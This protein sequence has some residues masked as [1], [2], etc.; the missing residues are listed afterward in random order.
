MI[1]AVDFSTVSSD[2]ISTAFCCALSSQ[3]C[4]HSICHGHRAC[5]SGRSCHRRHHLRPVRRRGT[6]CRLK[7]F[8]VSYFIYI[9]FILSC[10]H[11][12]TIFLEDSLRG[13]Q[14]LVKSLGG[15]FLLEK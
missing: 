5:R 11:I 9:Q 7:N 6:I 1:V 2:L 14:Q 13:A 15:S 10:F 3:I 12:V 8:E 4:N